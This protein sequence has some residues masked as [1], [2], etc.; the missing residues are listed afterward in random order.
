MH[1]TDRPSIMNPTIGADVTDFD[2]GAATIAFDR[3]IGN[4]APDVD[5]AKAAGIRSD[6]T[7][8]TWAPPVACR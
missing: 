3:P 7:R 6:D 1:V 8:L 4:K 2:R 5:P